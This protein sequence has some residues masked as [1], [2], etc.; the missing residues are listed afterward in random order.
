MSKKLLSILVHGYLNHSSDDSQGELFAI[1]EDIIGQLVMMGVLERAEGAFIE[2][3]CV[4]HNLVC[5]FSNAKQNC[6]VN[7]YPN[8]NYEVFYL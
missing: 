8:G 6:A 4:E 7:V 3:G 5:V 2:P 1:E